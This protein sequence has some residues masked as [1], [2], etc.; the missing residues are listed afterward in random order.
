MD[1]GYIS[2]FYQKVRSLTTST[3]PITLTN[4]LVGINQAGVSADGYL[5][6]T[7][8]NTFNNKAGVGNTWTLTGNTGINASTNFIGTTDNQSLVFK[9][10]NQL[11]G[12]IDLPLN[13][14]LFGYQAG[15]GITTGSNI[16]FTGYQSGYSNTTGGS[17]TGVGSIALFANTT[18]SNNTA[19]GYGALGSN[20][21]GS[22]NTATGNSALRNSTNS[23]SNSASEMDH[24]HLPQLVPAILLWEVQAA[25]PTLPVQTIHL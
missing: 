9:A 23:A 18:G 25:P 4:G 20:T 10:N 15:R 14:S 3:A 17:N 16:T 8:W 19:S 6:S 22:G 24:L 21:T 5:S 11:S 13:N 7:D 12:K 1:T 2:N